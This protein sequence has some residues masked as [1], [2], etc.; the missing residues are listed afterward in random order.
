MPD[1]TTFA[2]QWVT[3]WN[4]HDVEAVLAHFSDD[5]VFTSPVAA[6]LLPETGGVVRGKDALR[7]Y[8]ATALAAHPDLHFELIGIY[9]GSST[10]VINYRNH[11][12]QLVNEVLTFN[13]DG[14]IDEGHGTY[15]E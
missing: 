12:G 4:A 9:R 6:R 2:E 3:A 11:R 10:L 14:L 13:D 7:H 5:V 1:P 15:I 8:W